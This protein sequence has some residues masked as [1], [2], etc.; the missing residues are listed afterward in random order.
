MKTEKRGKIAH[1]ML[2]ISI[3][4]LFFFGIIILFLSTRLLSNTMYAEIESELGGAAENV[5]Y[6]L[7]LAYPGDYTLVGDSALQLHKGE[8]DLTREYSIVDKVKANTGFDVTLFYEDTRILT[9]ICDEDEKRIVGTGVSPI[10]LR[11]IRSDEKPHFYTNTKINNIEYFSYYAPLKNSD[12]SLVGLVF[13]GKPSTQ[14]ESSIQNVSYPLALTVL[15]TGLVIAF[16]LYLYTR[17]FDSVLQHIC[18]FLSSVSTENLNAELDK[19][20]LGRNDEFGDIGRSAVHMQQ[21]LRH[22]VEQD[23][24][25]KLYNRRSGD[26]RLNQVIEKSA[27]NGSPFCLSIGDIDFFKKVNDTYG[28]DCGDLVLKSVADIMREHMAKIGFVA[29]WGGEEFLLVFDR[30]EMEEAAESLNALLDKI[31]AAEILYGEQIIKV[32]MTF[33]LTPGDSSD[34][35]TLLKTADQKLYDGKAGGRN[36]V[37]I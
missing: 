4:P 35:S 5:I 17:K 9:T 7:D 12:G 32:T 2:V 21:E 26:R 23:A 28:H 10:V 19:S 37:V 11:D 13:I 3:V 27:V 14:I 24:L 22:T 6:M 15:L 18:V 33:G 16:F 31:R 25:T 1:V 8:H 20:V 29:R 30:M 34:H 36:R